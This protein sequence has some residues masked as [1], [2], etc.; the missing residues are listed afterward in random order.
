MRLGGFT[1]S[2]VRL[3]TL[4]GKTWSGKIFVGENFVTW[5]KNSSLFPDENYPRVIL[6]IEYILEMS[7]SYS[8]T[9]RSSRQKAPNFTE[10]IFQNEVLITKQSLW[11]AP[12][13]A[14][15]NFSRQIDLKIR[16][17]KFSHPP[18]LSGTVTF[19]RKIISLSGLPDVLILLN[20]LILEKLEKC[21]TTVL[22]IFNV[23]FLFWFS[24]QYKSLTGLIK[25]VCHWYFQFYH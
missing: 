5:R 10:F 21:P 7:R 24:F 8:N 18:L 17:V 9:F 23:K 4:K 22:L 15:K 25:R 11:N 3:N 12:T 13:M 2:L 16:R 20:L 14:D 6:C 19:S 1:A